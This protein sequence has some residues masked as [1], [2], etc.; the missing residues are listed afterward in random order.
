MLVFFDQLGLFPCP[1]GLQS[2]QAFLLD[3]SVGIMKGITF[4][5][6][7]LTGVILNRNGIRL[8]FGNGAER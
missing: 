7:K 6:R 2:V 3:W 5:S 1:S 4:G 8:L